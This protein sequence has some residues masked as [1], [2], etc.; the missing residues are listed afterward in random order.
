MQ[1]QADKKRKGQR[2]KEGEYYEICVIILKSNALFLLFTRW[3]FLYT[4]INPYDWS[5][6]WI[7]L[8]YLFC[9]L[10]FSALKRK[11]NGAWSS[12]NPITG[13]GTRKSSENEKTIRTQ[14]NW[15]KESSTKGAG[16]QLCRMQSKCST[17]TT[18][19]H[20]MWLLLRLSHLVIWH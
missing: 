11:K 9:W 7:L 10:L 18:H 3:I 19:S 13:E 2:A 17:T 20:T 4:L 6:A 1:H 5:V 14:R 12:K 16:N 8:Q 15:S